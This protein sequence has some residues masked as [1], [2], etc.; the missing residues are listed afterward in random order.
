MTCKCNKS[1]C[2]ACR[3]AA[4][5]REARIDRRS[6]IHYLGETLAVPFAP[7]QLVNID[8]QAYADLQRELLRAKLKAARLLNAALDAETV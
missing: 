3:A 6:L 8:G 1:W 5:A 2:E 7:A 4:D